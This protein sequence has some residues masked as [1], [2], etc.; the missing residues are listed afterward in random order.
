VGL[1]QCGVNVVLSMSHRCRPCG[2]RW[3]SLAVEVGVNAA[4]GRLGVWLVAKERAAAGSVQ[5]THAWPVVG[6]DMG[7]VTVAGRNEGDSRGDA[8]SIRRRQGFF[9]THLVGIPYHVSAFAPR[10]SCSRARFGCCFGRLRV[11]G[12]FRR[13]FAFTFV[14]GD[15][16]R[17][18]EMG[19]GAVSAVFAVFKILGDTVVAP[20]S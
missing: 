14:F 6:I 10:G 16:R 7:S 18:R 1:S 5:S 19:R 8:I 17:S 9:H 4:A 12:W 11:R 2:R 15:R 13:P 20:V 3:G